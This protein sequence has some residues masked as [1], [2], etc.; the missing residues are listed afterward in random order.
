M[1][2]TFLDASTLPV[3]LHIMTLL[4]IMSIMN[5]NTTNLNVGTREI[6]S[7]LIN[8]QHYIICSV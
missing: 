1:I 2:I 8:L 6:I 5:K 4:F 3:A 7:I